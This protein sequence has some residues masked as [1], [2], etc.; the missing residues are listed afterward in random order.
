M[1]EDP[2]FEAHRVELEN[3]NTTWFSHY[4]KGR[5]VFEHIDQRLPGEKHEAR[6]ISSDDGMSK[7]H[8]GIKP[9]ERLFLHSNQE[10]DISESTFEK[11]HQDAA[12]LIS[13]IINN[14]APT[15]TTV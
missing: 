6:I 4:A 13:N 11:I 15:T 1:V 8:Y 5:E 14:F 10:W 9:N 7:L 12:T 2:A 3:L